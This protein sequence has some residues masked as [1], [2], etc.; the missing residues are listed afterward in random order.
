M[1]SH[2]WPII[3]LDILLLLAACRPSRPRARRPLTPDWPKWSAARTWEASGLVHDGSV[4]GLYRALVD[5]PQGVAISDTRFWQHLP[6]PPACH[7]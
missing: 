2:W 6:P 7:D 5:V 3:V 4:G 1:I